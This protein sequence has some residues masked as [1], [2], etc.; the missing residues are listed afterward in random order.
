[1]PPNTPAPT[2]TNASAALAAAEGT[3]EALLAAMKKFL[4][5][6][7]KERLGV[8]RML[9]TEVKN[10]EKNDVATPGRTRT[11]AEVIALVAAYHKNLAKSLA[12]FPPDRQEPL[13]REMAIVE[14]FLPRQLSVE[15]L[16]ADVDAF[17]AATTERTF[18]VLMKSLQPRYA[19]RAD[20]RLVSETLKTAL[21][22]V[23]PSASENEKGRAH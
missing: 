16:R 4:V 2:P 9:V 1:M 14:S 18:G 11:E 21:A 7:D 13:R 3:R 19:G 17:L 22:S 5:E 12:E 6:G 23:Q 20:G 8:V 15:E 10:A